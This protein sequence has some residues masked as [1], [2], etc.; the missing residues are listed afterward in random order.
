M[1]QSSYTPSTSTQRRVGWGSK[2]HTIQ[3]TVASCRH[4]FWLSHSNT[5]TTIR[6]GMETL[7][8][9]CQTWITHS[10]TY[11]PIL[12]HSP[13]GQVHIVCAFVQYNLSPDSV[14]ARRYEK[15][16]RKFKVAGVGNSRIVTTIIVTLLYY[17]FAHV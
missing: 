1:Y 4:C 15:P 2:V 10:Q 16:V 6:V 14:E 3:S 11:S 5:C 7:P 13:K 9:S 17:Y 8:R 12:A